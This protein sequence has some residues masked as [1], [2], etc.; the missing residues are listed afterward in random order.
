VPRHP[1]RLGRSHAVSSG[2]SRRRSRPRTR[3]PARRP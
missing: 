3:P 1:R 2:P